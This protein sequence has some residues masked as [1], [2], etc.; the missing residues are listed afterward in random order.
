MKIKE[1]F[2]LRKVADTWVVMS[3]Y[4]DTVDFNGMLSLN[5]SGVML[6]KVLEQGGDKQALVKALTDSY[7]VTEQQAANDV[8]EFLN[9]L[10]GAGCLE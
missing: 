6:W 8:D 3:L 7:D 2:L 4:E 10:A 9:V 1:N 5:E